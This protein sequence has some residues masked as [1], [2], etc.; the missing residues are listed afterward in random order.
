MREENSD[1]RESLDDVRRSLA[2]EDRGWQLIS[3]V[4]AGDH[5]DG[6]TLLEVKEISETIRPYI[7]GASLMLRGVNLRRG[8]VWSRGVHIEG[9]EEPKGQ[10]RPP[11]LRT[12]YEKK[13]NQASLFS[14]SA[15]SE[16][17]RSAFTDGVVIG[18]CYTAINEVRRIP[19]IEVSDL[20][21]N[22]DFPDEI[23]AIQRTWNDGTTTKTRWFYTNAFTGRKQT[24]I[25]VDGQR[26]P[27][28]ANVIAVIKRF[29]R[30]SGWPMGIPDATAALPWYEAYSEIMRYGRVVNEALAKLL[31][32]VTSPTKKANNN[33][34]AKIA[35]AEGHGKTAAM[36][37][38]QDIQAISTA[39]KGYDFTSARPVAAMMAAALDVPNIELLSDSA[40]AGSSY[41]AAQSLTPSTINAMRFRQD[42]W[43]EFFQD[44]FSVFRLGSPKISFDPIVEPD[45]YRT[46]QGIILGS[47]A[48]SDVEYRRLVLDH[49]NI[50]G[51]PAEIPPSLAIRALAGEPFPRS[52]TQAA[53][54]DQGVSNGAGRDTGNSNDLRSDVLSNSLQEDAIRLMETLV[55]RLERLK[56]E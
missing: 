25:T 42:E 29:N 56:Q 1:L 55:E 31:Y 43:V 48:L 10:G 33:A 12:F 15:H 3:G 22:P 20:R 37:E 39:G 9:T 14:A 41:G 34:S 13:A 17:E 50:A 27:V 18:L 19:L 11:A 54:P 44:I 49:F 2:F 7:I 53:A 36:V 6:L 16:M 26:H 8:Y 45:F 32:K 35:A 23:W 21:F 47:Q 40:A 52:G 46:M 51:D 30:Q 28:E 24:S 38:G 4:M 5:A